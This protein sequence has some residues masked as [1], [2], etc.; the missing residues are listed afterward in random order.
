MTEEQKKAETAKLEA[1]KK[2]KED[3]DAIA[4][5]AKDDE[6]GEEDEGADD[7]DIETPDYES[8]LKAEREAREKAEQALADKRFKDSERKRKGDDDQDGEEDESDEDDKPLTRKDLQNLL[9]RERQVTQ[10]ELQADS[11]VKIATELSDSEPEAKLVAEIYKN[12]T[13]PAH[14][15]LREQLEEAHAIANRR[16]LQST[17]SELR[18]ALK[19]K[20]VASNDAASSHK[21]PLAGTA[22]KLSTNDAAS[23]TRAGFTFDTARKIYRKKLPNG[24]FHNKDPK[25]KK[26]FITD[27]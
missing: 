10:K 18:R 8:L 21:D 5:A 12:R 3:A 17:N 27:N 24:K 22:P 4:A 14:L 7:E 23:Y 2:A 13:W 15:S 6:S 19:A 26:T 16:K 9:A 25:T 11:I 1:D 20:S